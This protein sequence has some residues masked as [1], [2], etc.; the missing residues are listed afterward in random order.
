MFAIHWFVPLPDP[1]AL[2][3]GSSW[4]T[5]PGTDAGLD[6][7]SVAVRQLERPNA[8]SFF[9]DMVTAASVSLPG[10]SMESE[11]QEGNDTRP[12][13]VS[14]VVA[15]FDTPE[16]PAEEALSDAFDLGLSALRRVLRSYALVTKDPVRMPTREAL[17]PMLLMVRREIV[18][19]DQGYPGT[20]SVYLVSFGSVRTHH[21]PDLDGQTLERVNTAYAAPDRAFSNYV[22]LRLD[23]KRALDRDGDYR[24]AVLATATAAE[25]LLDDVLRHVLW[26]DGTRPEDAAKLFTD[27]RASAASRVPREHPRLLGGDWDP[28]GTGPV[29]GWR[30]AIAEVRHRVVH[31]GY[32]PSLDDA[33]RAVEALTTLERHVI[34]IVA[35]PRNIK[36]RLWTALSLTG[37]D[38][39]S[40]RGKLSKSVKARMDGWRGPDPAS[41]FNH[42]RRAVSDQVAYERGLLKPFDPAA[43]KVFVVR[44]ANGGVTWFAV[45]QEQG[46]AAPMRERWSDLANGGVELRSVIAGLDRDGVSRPVSIRIDGDIIGGEIIGDWVL[47]YRAIPTNEVMI[48]GTDF[49]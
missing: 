9:D 32:E 29:A 1:V 37:L 38:G 46:F 16:M 14:E 25:I 48:D 34:D 31:A 5:S 17:P 30:E 23:A 15:L 11:R 35:S 24:S 42:W 18:G 26:E 2:P 39:L 20:P 10:F 19:K 28:K 8:T 33:R 47:V 27:S 12:V 45:D 36:K 41:T 43:A 44:A 6:L 7:V 3:E 13:T 22:G 21:R 49:A 4:T 40:R